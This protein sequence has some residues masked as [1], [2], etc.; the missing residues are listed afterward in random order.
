GQVVAYYRGTY[1]QPETGYAIAADGAGN[2]AVLADMGRS[3][4][5]TTWSPSQNALPHSGPPN[6]HDVTIIKFGTNAFS[7]DFGGHGHDFGTAIAFD[8]QGNI[9]VAGYTYSTD[10]PT[11][12]AYQSTLSGSSDAFL[13]KIDPTGTQLL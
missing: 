11:H 5:G 7:T 2:V 10:F 6:D 8:G 4:C 13:S 12:S 9:Y 1:C 3:Y